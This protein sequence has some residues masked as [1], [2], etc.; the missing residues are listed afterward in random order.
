MMPTSR[1]AMMRREAVPMTPSGMKET[2]AHIINKRNTRSIRDLKKITKLAAKAATDAFIR[3]RQPPNEFEKKKNRR[4]V[5]TAS[6]SS[7]LTEASSLFDGRR[8]YDMEGILSHGQAGLYRRNVKKPQKN[9]SFSTVTVREYEVILGDNPSCSSGPS[10]GIGWNYDKR[11]IIE[12][13][14]D[15]Y[16]RCSQEPLAERQLVVS[17]SERWRRLVH[18]GYSQTQIASAVR[19]SNSRRRTINKKLGEASR[20]I[21]KASK[22]VSRLLGNSDKSGYTLEQ[23]EN[24]NNIKLQERNDFD[25]IFYLDNDSDAESLY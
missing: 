2:N 9:V 12:T 18:V 17:S 20:R 21:R 15:N 24:S 16:E 14:V 19:I 23:Y 5:R 10:L 22:K 8:S 3:T 11:K 1:D 25:A 6:I 7:T 13:T 4:A